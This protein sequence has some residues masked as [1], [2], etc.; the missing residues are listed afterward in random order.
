MKTRIFKNF[1]TLIMVTILIGGMMS[2]NNSKSGCTSEVNAQVNMT[3]DDA[4][5][6][7]KS[8][9]GQSVDV[10]YAYGAQCVDLIKAYYTFLGFYPVKGNG[11]DYTHNV[12]PP[13]YVRIKDAKPQKGDILVYTGGGKGYGHVA[14]YESDYSTYHQNFGG[15]QY[16]MHVTHI[17]YNGMTTVN[18][19]GVIRP[20]FQSVNDIRGF[21]DVYSAGENSLYVAGWAADFYSK[22]TNLEI[23]IFIG[24]AAE[25]EGQK[26]TE[27]H[28][29]IAD[30]LRRDVEAAF[31]GVG[32]NHGYEA[33]LLTSLTGKQTV[34][35]YAVNTVNNC[36][37]LIDKENVDIK[38]GIVPNEVKL[39]Q[40]SVTLTPAK[41]KVSLSATVLPDNASVKDI[42]WTSSNPSVATVNSNGVVYSVGNG[43]TT[44]TATTIFGKVKTDCQIEVKDFKYEG[45]EKASN[46]SWYYYQDGIV[47]KKY[48]GMAKNQYGWWYMKNGTL[49]RSYTGMAKNQY[50]WWYMTNGALDRSYTGMAKNQYGWWYMTNGALDR[51]YTGIGNNQYGKWY[52]KQGALQGSF[53]GKI[54]I[55]NKTYSIKNGKVN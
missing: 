30:K 31:P 23:Q 4:V 19:W 34:Y 14:I 9:V 33:N 5:K 12:L 25:T 55:N 28:V 26:G 40:S 38:K 50:G 3:A 2:L 6:W 39:S 18:Y 45:M 49:D 51:T 16:V 24:G 43:K 54:T 17:P 47:D 37:I 15:N 53:S 42:I 10:D 36:R 44:I 41:S 22:N 27:K 7:A 48:T 46:G 21:L 8:K 29:I 11:S 35:V 32:K 20:D 52:M 1:L 13:G